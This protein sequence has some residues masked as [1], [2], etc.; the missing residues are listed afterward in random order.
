MSKKSFFIKVINL[1]SS[2][3]SLFKPDINY[4]NK[5]LHSVLSDGLY[6][7]DEITKD[8]LLLKSF[9]EKYDKTY[10]TCGSE[11][12]EHWLYSVKDKNQIEN[13]QADIKKLRASDSCDFLEVLLQNKIGKQ[14]KGNFIRDLWNGFSVK[15]W[16]I[17]NFTLLFLFNLIFSITGCLLF[18]K[19]ILFFIIF[20]FIYN[21]ALFLLT[22]K[23]ISHITSS[24][25]YFLTLCS[26]LKKID[27]YTNLQLS[28][29]MPDYKRFSKLQ[30]YSLFFKEGIGGPSSGD[31]LSILIDYFRIFLAAELFSF[32]R[33][34]KILLDNIEE[35]RKIFLYIGYIDCLLNNLR[36]MAEKDCTFATI[37][38]KAEISFTNMKHPLL[39]NSIGQTKKITSNLIVTGLNMSGKTTF[40]KSLGLN[41]LLATSFGFAFA[42]K[43]QAPVLDLLSS[44]TINDQLLKGKSRY[45][46]EAE[47]LLLIKEKIENHKCLCLIDEILSGT[48]S[49]ERIYGSSKILKD[50]AKSDSFL[51]AATHDTQIAENLNQ[52]YEPVY[53]DGEIEGDRIKFDYTIKQGIVSKRNG[54]LILKLLGV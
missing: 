37:T 39:E 26:S 33:V 27:K 52:L 19:Y 35:L 34:K 22:N 47:R 25:G 28:L 15:S 53:F 50:F 36:I 17:D 5:P 7:I 10:T 48:N 29:E 54:L 4:V 49:D 23:L 32:N 12:F 42:E 1:F 51:I 9:I 31:I 13:L 6:N 8:D 24:I 14:K 21:F 20:F 41:Q 11:V 3:F 38:D 45:Y 43:Y 40:M 30:K 44:I 18:R 16:L 46:A 2:F